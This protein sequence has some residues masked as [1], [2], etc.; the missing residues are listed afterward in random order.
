MDYG[1]SLNC[2]W[3]SAMR[4]KLSFNK[5]IKGPQWKFA[6]LVPCQLKPV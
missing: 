4:T 1:R 6:L 5:K 2:A 3:M